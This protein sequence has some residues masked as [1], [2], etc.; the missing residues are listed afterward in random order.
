[1]NVEAIVKKEVTANMLIIE[2]KKQTWIIKFD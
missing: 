1:M 2:M